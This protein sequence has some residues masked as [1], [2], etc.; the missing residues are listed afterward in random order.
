[1]VEDT[2]TALR[3]NI[4][5]TYAKSANRKLLVVVLFI[6]ASAGT[7]AAVADDPPNGE[8]PAALRVANDLSEAFS[9]AAEKISPSVVSVRSV[10]HAKPSAEGRG[11][12]PE[13]LP[14]GD[15]F[16]RRFF[17]DRLPNQL[18]P[19]VGMGSG[20]VVSPDGYILTNNHVV[21]DADEVT[22]TLQDKTDY[23]AD[24]VGKDPLSDLAVIR[25]KAH[26]LPAAKLGNSD[27]LKV[28]E[29]VVAAGNPFGLT[30]T[31]TAGIVSAKGRSNVRIAEYEDFIQT[32]AAINP[33][34]SGGPLVNLRGEVVGINTAIASRGGG[35]NGVGFAIP[36]SMAKSIMETLIGKGHV[37]RGWLGVSIQPLSEGMAKSFDYPSTDG[38][39]IGFVLKGGPA[40]Q[41]GVQPGDIVTSFDG[42]KLK[43]STQLRNLVA[44]AEPGTKAKLEVFRGGKTKTITVE[45]AERSEGEGTGETGLGV[46]DALGLTTTNLTPDVRRALG[47]SGYVE[48]V[49]ITEVDPS[50]IAYREGLRAGQVILEVQGTPVSSVAQFKAQVAKQDLKKG[51][52]LRVQ[53]ADQQMYVLLQA[54]K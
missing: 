35:N 39:L 20:V 24:V 13:G 15:D 17:G 38:A 42:T 50:G 19:Q 53:V 5:S 40:E 47:L 4:M 3:R 2:R 34:N 43:D 1:M 25:V 11:Q 21:G 18:P 29:W 6:L 49:A 23:H 51:I 33:G 14:F 52:R 41:A 28:G 12:L 31:I 27:E 16:L 26:D 10:K 30:D 48:G 32:D 45:L 36:I 9:Y 37:T 54:E 7:L 22:V 8:P 46:T 44:A